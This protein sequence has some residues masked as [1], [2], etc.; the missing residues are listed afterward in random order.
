MAPTEEKNNKLK[1]GE[2]RKKGKKKCVNVTTQACVRAWLRL[3]PRYAYAD[4]FVI[5]K[6]TASQSK[7][8]GKTPQG[9]TIKVRRRDMF[10]S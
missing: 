2:M 5:Q 10:Q 9:Y 1:Q 7:T 8:T 4:E 3:R 6:E